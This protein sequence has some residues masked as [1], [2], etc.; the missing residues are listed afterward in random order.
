M[1]R[2]EVEVRVVS[3]GFAAVLLLAACSSSTT[4]IPQSSNPAGGAKIKHVVILLQENRSFNSLFMGFPGAE[5]ASSGPC[6]IKKS[7]PWCKG[8]PITLKP[9]SLESVGPPIGTDIGHEHRDFD[10]ECDRDTATG[11]CRMDGFDLDRYGV[12]GGEKRAKLYPYR[13]VE[14]SE[15]KPYWDLA[16]RYAIA[17]HM[18]FTETA[19]SFIAHQEIISGTVRLNSTR[20][21]TDEPDDSIWGCDAFPGT[22]TPVLLV[23]G[24]ELEPGPSTKLPFPCFTE[25]PTMA[26]VLDAANVS[27]KYYVA[28]TFGPRG[29]FS[30]GVWNGFDAIKKVRYGPDWKEHISRP[31]T[32][33]FAD[34]KSDSLSSVSWVMPTVA[35]SDHPASGCNSGPRWVTKVVNAIGTSQYWKD[36]AIVLMW[37]DW[38]GWYDPVAPPRIN[39][40]SLGFRVPMIVISPY[41]RPGYVSHTQYQFG[42]VLKFV[43]QT[44]KLG[45]LGTSDVN[46]NS[47][48]DN[49][50]FTQAPLG[51]KSAP[52]PPALRLCEKE[53]QDDLRPLFRREGFPDYG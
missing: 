39:Y 13:Y 23:D 26:D 8:Q 22:Q 49:F 34:L 15:T 46:A 53:Q 1:E 16:S 52:L 4:T 44:F 18:F 6:E 7:A 42:S 3:F 24:R 2:E 43:E 33:F 31:N 14:R 47:I 27:W 35:D 50:N 41:A 38:G 36:T 40:A 45:S 30:G 21:L 17:D 10:A 28:P 9:V 11:V 12:S 5:T 32:N 37:D 25:Y 51:F 29:D 48:E 19:A 20:S